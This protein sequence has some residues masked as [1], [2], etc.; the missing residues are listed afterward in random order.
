MKRYILLFAI[1]ITAIFLYPV[2]AHAQK[3]EIYFT[4][5]PISDPVA[6][7]VLG[8]GLLLAAFLTKRLVKY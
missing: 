4:Q 7:I 6:L 1:C 2:F 3:I 5:N 8:S